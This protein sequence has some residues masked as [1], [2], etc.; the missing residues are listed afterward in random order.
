MAEPI[1]F[2]CSDASN[3]VHNERIADGALRRE[4]HPQFARRGERPHGLANEQ[5]WDRRSWLA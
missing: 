5:V 4:E 3:G 1:L 2:L